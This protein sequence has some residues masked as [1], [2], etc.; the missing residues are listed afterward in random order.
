MWSPRMFAAVVRAHPVRWGIAALAAVA[1][2][3]AL[4]VVTGLG[5]PQDKAQPGAAPQA[6]PSSQATP[7]SSRGQLVPPTTSSPSASRPVSLV[8]SISLRPIS[9]IDQRACGEGASGIPG[10]GPES[11]PAGWCYHAAQGLTLTR[12][13]QIG[14]S[15]F[16]LEGRR[17]TF[18]LDVCIAPADRTPF[19]SLLRRS[20]GHLIAIVISGRV[21][22]SQQLSQQMPK[23]VLTFTNG[24]NPD[25]FTQ[26]QA[27][28]LLRRLTGGVTWGSAMPRVCSR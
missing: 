16:Q 9:G 3:T 14:V 22:A 11:E 6:S 25:G 23:T 7:A 1:A 12:V 8:T 17:S 27:N 19:T 24:W 26:A 18:N 5:S 4:F 10:P 28:R 21:V 2:L 13:Q 15:S 20:A